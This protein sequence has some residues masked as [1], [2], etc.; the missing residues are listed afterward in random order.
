MDTPGRSERGKAFRTERAAGQ[1][2]NSEQASLTRAGLL[3]SDAA[4]RIREGHPKGRLLSRRNHG[5]AVVRAACQDS[6]SGL[7]ER[8][9][10]DAVVRWSREGAGHWGLSKSDREGGLHPY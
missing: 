9:S 5:R 2:E 8:G 1:R 3:M 6:L 4:W 10:T 7:M